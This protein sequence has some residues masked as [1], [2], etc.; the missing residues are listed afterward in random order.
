MRVGY[1]LAGNDDK[2][3]SLKVR[4]LKGGTDILR[5]FPNVVWYAPPRESSVIKKDASYPL[6]CF[7]IPSVECSKLSSW[8]SSFLFPTSGLFLNHPVSKNQT[9]NAKAD[10]KDAKSPVVVKG[11]GHSEVGD[12]VAVAGV[13]ESYTVEGDVIDGLFDAQVDVT[14]IVVEEEIT[15]S[16]SF[17]VL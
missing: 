1:E 15:V 5:K 6:F 14:D 3:P 7:F 12:D 4:I 8:P 10:N 16:L 2:N 13:V 9:E 11:K 17:S